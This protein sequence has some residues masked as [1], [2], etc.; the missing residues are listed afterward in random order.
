MQ[1][2]IL[3]ENV[4]SDNI[5]KLADDGKVFKGQYIAIVEEYA[6]Q[7]AW[8]DTLRKVHKFR[9]MERL[10]KFLAK[11]YPHFSI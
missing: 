3:Q 10:N 11:Q 6:F 4:L 1:E 2:F 7:N 5:L 9:S 8:C